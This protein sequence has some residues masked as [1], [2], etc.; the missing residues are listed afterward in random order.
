MLRKI[1]R[2]ALLSENPTSKQLETL[3]SNLKMFPEMAGVKNTEFVDELRSYLI[4]NENASIWEAMLFS[5]H[6]RMFLAEGGDEE[7][8]EKDWEETKSDLLGFVEHTMDL[9]AEQVLGKK[10]E[11]EMEKR[12]ENPTT[13]H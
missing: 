10:I 13:I 6:K 3:T 9:R 8:T 2:E 5:F 12:K 7:S 11:E 4:K 1:L